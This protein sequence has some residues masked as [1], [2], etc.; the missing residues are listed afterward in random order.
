MRTNKNPRFSVIVPT[1]ER[2]KTLKH[3]L[4]SLQ[5]Q[6]GPTFEIIVSDNFSQDDTM[7]IVDELATE[8]TKYY[9][10]SNSC[11]MSENWE[12]ALGY[13]SGDYVTVVGDDDT[14]L[15]GA[16]DSLNSLLL[17]FDVDAISW[18]KVEYCWPDHPSLPN[19]IS[20]PMKK[21]LF[22][23]DSKFALSMVTKGLLAYSRTP[24]LYNSVVKRTILENL[25]KRTGRYFWASTPDVYS[26]VAILSEVGKY[27][28]SA[29][30]F[31]VN[32]ASS[33]SNGTAFINDHNGN[34]TKRF[35]TD[36]DDRYVEGYPS[37]KGSVQSLIFEAFFQANLKCFNNNLKVSKIAMT[38]KIMEEVSQLDKKTYESAILILK[39]SPFLI[40]IKGLMN[41][42]IAK[43][44]LDNFKKSKNQP[45][46]SDS[47]YIKLRLPQN[48][49]SNVQDA[50]N[51]SSEILGKYETPST[52]SKFN[53]LN[54]AI[55]WVY[56]KIIPLLTKRTL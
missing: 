53:R 45:L 22:S 30:P 25:K 7:T 52:Y 50:A 16:L 11:S 51:L 9:R 39:S 49:F 18:E 34:K 40:E 28:Y 44:P 32:G 27:L 8:N 5:E 13:A 48:M 3:T 46:V 31:S 17:T 10:T 42:I 29:R 36:M 37:V 24:T 47:D 43:Y 55:T 12:I 14:L 15:P 19:F 20:I 4:L 23:I 26:G 41:Q 21:N 33:Q 38:R 6:K 1:R 2:S 56:R 35:Y 54:L